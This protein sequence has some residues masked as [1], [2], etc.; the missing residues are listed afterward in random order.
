VCH[1]HQPIEQH[2]R[3]LLK[4]WAEGLRYGK[5]QMPV[6]YGKQDCLDRL[7]PVVSIR[8]GTR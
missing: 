2:G 3:M 5:R 6:G 8:F 1:L 4:E 7:D